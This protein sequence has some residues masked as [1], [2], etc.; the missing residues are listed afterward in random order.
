MSYFDDASLAFLPSGAAGKDGKAYSIKPE[1]GTG[2]FTFTRGSNLA[3][4]RVGPGPNFYIEKGRENLALQSNQFDTTWLTTR[5]SVTSGQSGYDGTN[6][7]WKI[8][9]TNP[10]DGV[11]DHY[12][13]QS[14]SA[15]GVL[16][17]SGYFKAAEK[18]TI[19]ILFNNSDPTPRADFDLA[20]GSVHNK[21]NTIDASIV[22]VGNSW[23]RCS[24][25]GILT[26]NALI[27]I[28]AT[29]S[30]NV[31]SWVGDDT[32]G[33][34]IQD[35]QLEQ[36]LVAT[37]YIET[38][39]ST[40]QAGILEDTPRFDYSGGATCP[41][42]L[43]EPARTQLF[44]KSE[45]FGDSY[46]G[47]TSVSVTNNATTSPEGVGNAAKLIPDNGTGGNRSLSI[48]YTSLTGLHTFSVYAKAGEYGYLY[49][50][51]RNS[52]SARAIFDLTNGLVHATNTTAQMVS[53]SPTIEAVGTDG[54]YRCSIVLDPS[55]SATAGQ[56][57][58]SYSV[59]ITG[60]ETNAFDGDGTSGIYIWGAQFTASSHISS[61]IPNHSGGTITRAA[62]VCG[63]AG[64]VN[65]F[66]S[67]EGVLYVEIASLVG[68][69]AVGQ[70][71]VSNGS[72]NENVKI[73]W[74]NA[75]KIRL[76]V[77]TVSGTN[78]VKDINVERNGDFYKLA[79]QYK[80]NDY[81]VYVNGISQ[82]VSQ[83]ASTPNGLNKLNFNRGDGGSVFYGN[84]KQVLTFNTALSDAD[85]AALTT[86]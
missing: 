56:L 45:Y 9:G 5:S 83:V 19:R 27:Q 15:T 39:A 86:I 50:R 13:R 38:G 68:D 74:L 71:S 26:T 54:W 77:K 63:G 73:L 12:L 65:T 64:D 47:K 75:N 67:T 6:N 58:V 35:A 8:T 11:K 59:G 60:D 34:Y 18:T 53:G 81:K 2:D 72:D 24:V 41:S 28:Y 52:P 55:G 3:A 82:A 84:V 32:S 42:L 78:F 76:E 51:L 57:Y 29:E 25:T 44:N 36:G 69:E 48:N 10:A 21:T 80:S 30:I 46:W 17:I 49:L 31:T 70:M 14:Y 43:L 61:Y 40:A 85:L 33:V 79:I 22:D 7:A 23:Y 16:T 1:D 62:D 4:T 20:N 66:N 37:D